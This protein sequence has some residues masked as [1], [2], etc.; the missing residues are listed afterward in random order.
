MSRSDTVDKQ[1]N[2]ANNSK[3]KFTKQ[4]LDFDNTK[5][6]TTKTTILGD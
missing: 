5:F 2:N 6:M 3:A 4:L 1:R